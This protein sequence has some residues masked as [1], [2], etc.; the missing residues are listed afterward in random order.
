MVVSYRDNEGR[1]L[2]AI[3]TAKFNCTGCIH[4]GGILFWLDPILRGHLQST[5]YFGTH[6]HDSDRS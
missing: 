2:F 5:K 6:K 1:V 3:D 4:A